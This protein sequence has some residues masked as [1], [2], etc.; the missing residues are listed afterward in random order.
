MQQQ[1]KQIQIENDNLKTQIEK[2]NSIH[3]EGAGHKRKYMEGAVWMGKKLSNEI[4]KTC[5]SFEFLI[6]EY[7]KR[8]AE[9]ADHKRASHWLIE[10]VK[11]SGFD[12]YEKTI[13]IL[14]S[15]IFHMEDAAQKNLDV[16]T[17][18]M[19]ANLFTLP[20]QVDTQQLQQQL[21]QILLQK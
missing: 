4:E 17:I 14:E 21:D 6:M 19:P 16:K 18:A 5:Q 9:E 3:K 15:A 13:T 1:K 11:H 12:L 2:L 20:E 10:A 8:L 7:N